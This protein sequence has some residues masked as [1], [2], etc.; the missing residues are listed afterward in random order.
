M[1]PTKPM[2]PVSDLRAANAPTRKEPSCSLNTTFCT[3]ASGTTISIKVNLVSGYAWAAALTALAEEKPTATMGLL[4]R[5][6]SFLRPCSTCASFVGSTSRT[7][8]PVSAVKRLTPLK[9]ASL[10]DLSNLPALSYTTAGLTSA[11][12]TVAVNATAPA[13][14][15]MV[16]LF[17]FITFS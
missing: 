15:A 14:I 9:T 12:A 13:M 1:P 6:A 3:L 7:L 8:I 5:L 16:I 4:P 2:V 17:N 10:N 11:C